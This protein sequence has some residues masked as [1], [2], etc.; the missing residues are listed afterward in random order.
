MTLGFFKRSPV[1]LSAVE[2]CPELFDE[3]TVKSKFALRE[4]I[5]NIQQAQKGGLK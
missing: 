4:K 1:T 2:G 3:D 5:S